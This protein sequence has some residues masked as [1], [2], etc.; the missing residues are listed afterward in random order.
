MRGLVLLLMILAVAGCAGLPAPGA[1][2]QAPA[3][4]WMPEGE[5]RAQI[6]ALHGLN[7]HKNAFA[8]FAEAA[9][10]QG[11][12]VHAYDQPG[13]GEQPDRGFWPGRDRLIGEVHRHVRER[14]AARP[15]LPL[16]VLG[17]SMGA[18]VAIAALAAPG[19][20][21][22]DGLILSAPAVWGGT[23]MNPLYRGLLWTVARTMPWLKLSGRGLGRRASDNLEI[24]RALGRDPL[25]IKE[26]RA[27]TLEGLVLLMG[28]AR[29]LGPVLGLPILVLVGERDEIVPTDAQLSFLAELGAAPCTAI[30]Y[31]EGW[32]LLLR[33]L[34]RELVWQDVLAWIGGAA[35]PS[36][37]ARA[38]TAVEGEGEGG[39]SA[40]ALPGP[41]TGPAAPG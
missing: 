35:P 27:D 39:R 38:C 13:F 19:A 21:P 8:A 40:G 28:E 14:R 23:S 12:L 2:E 30:V 1:A 37:L 7:D 5:P 18:A 33:D 34:Q 4:R 9:A 25:F 17:E 6:V 36:G 26:T 11:V 29:R 20:P 15:D 41:M 10:G 31:P 22:V 3:L 24:L 32:H 16:F